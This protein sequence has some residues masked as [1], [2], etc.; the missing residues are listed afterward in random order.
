[1][2]EKVKV[3]PVFNSSS[4]SGDKCYFRDDI[5]LFRQTA[6]GHRLLFF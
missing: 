3:N 4:Q 2:A 5:F 1:M 6:V